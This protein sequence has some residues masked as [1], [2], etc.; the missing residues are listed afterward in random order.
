M[1]FL[2]LKFMQVLEDLTDIMHDPRLFAGLVEQLHQ[3]CIFRAVNL[4]VIAE[5]PDV[6]AFQSR[7]MHIQLGIKILP[8]SLP[9][10]Q[11]HIE[12]QNALHPGLDAAFQKPF[13]ILPGIIDIG[14]DG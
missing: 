2:L 1:F 14:K 8:A 11:A 13:N 7:E 10:G 4:I 5:F 9:E 6:L 3:L 12:A